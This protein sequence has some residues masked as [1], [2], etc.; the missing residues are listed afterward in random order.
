VRLTTNEIQGEKMKVLIV[1]TSVEEGLWLAEL[2]HPYW[3]LSERHVEIDIASP[4]G[5]KLVW[6]GISD[7][8]NAN[9][10]E[11][12]DIV[13]KGFLS[14]KTL[15]AKLQTTLLLADVDPTKYDGIHVAGGPGPA[16]DLY[17]NADMGKI[18][19]HFFSAGKIV[20][21]ICHGTIALGNNP[22]RIKGRQ[23]TGY[24]LAEDQVWEKIL[25]K[26]PF[27]PNYPQPTLEKAGAIYS[28]APVDGLR[29]VVDRKLV[30]GQ[31]QWSA[32]E[33]ALRLYHLSTG[34]TPVV[35]A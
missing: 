6:I 14:D 35:F 29:V 22:E 12:N 18:L 28:S 4:K 3:H 30:T 32:S 20:G 16:I 26:K 33:Y 23:L 7:P 5:G 11:A 10:Q 31:N 15:V 2:T 13:S 24:S 21:A 25:D 8:Y 17:P 19:E 1:A 9:S 27:L 34:S